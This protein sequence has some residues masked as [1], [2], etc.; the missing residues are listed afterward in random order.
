MMAIRHH[1]SALDG[2]ADLA[3]PGAA[4]VLCRIVGGL[5]LLI[6]P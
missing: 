2:T 3:A 6:A 4:L 1:I 5:L